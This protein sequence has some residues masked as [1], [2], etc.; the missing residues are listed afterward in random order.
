MPPPL[1]LELPSLAMKTVVAAAIDPRVGVMF[2]IFFV[3]FL[4]VSFPTLSR[5]IHIPVIIFFIGK[6]FGTGVI[7]ATAFIHLLDDAFRSLQSKAVEERYG[8]MGHRTG[9]IILA[10]LL[11]IFLVEYISTSYVEHLHDKPSA[12]PTPVGSLPPSRPRSPKPS[13]STT[14]R[15]TSR[16]NPEEYPPQKVAVTI[17]ETTPLLVG[18][19]KPACEPP[20]LDGTRRPIARRDHHIIVGHG[21]APVIAAAAVAGLPIEVL[22]NSPRICRLAVAHDRRGDHHNTHHHSHEN[23]N[24]EAGEDQYDKKPH[25]RIGRR[26]QIVS[27]LVL[28]LGIMIHSL[29]IGLT[30]SVASGSEFTSLTTA[31]IF[32]QLFEG[33]S[34]GIRIAALPPKQSHNPEPEHRGRLASRNTNNEHSLSVDDSS[35]TQESR[36]V[37]SPS[38]SPARDRERNAAIVS[39]HALTNLPPS[40]PAQS[41]STT[42]L[43]QSDTVE[44][45]SPNHKHSSNSAPTA[46]S[47]QWKNW[48]AN[49]F[50]AFDV[51]RWRVS[52]GDRKE[53]HWLKPTLSL[54]FAVTTP[55]GIAIGMA[56]WGDNNG[57]R[58]QMLVIQGIMSAI[59]AGMLIYAATVEMIAG[60]FVFGDVEGHHHHHHHGHDDAEVRKSCS[61]AS[62]VARRGEERIDVED[63]HLATVG[64]CEEDSLEGKKDPK[65]TMAKKVLAVVSLLAGSSMMVLVGLGE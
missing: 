47:P 53:V 31:I 5:K 3:S 63:H 55:F 65:A 60:D 38:A 13:T 16:D 20:A 30:L 43:T 40:S 23:I 32:H 8:K 24:I 7:L 39:C 18:G 52:L 28:Q 48:V 46:N 17:T 26:R 6:H 57:D 56:V 50:H 22:T 41:Q 2:T 4:A 12:P 59:S 36:T 25:P 33:L 14:R 19:T 21:S 62:S 27:I 37:P 9:L 29:V 49:V 11:S 42:P 54:L 15:S 61:R 58:A 44:C 35:A 1:Q 64:G 45:G 34:L 10:S 51:R